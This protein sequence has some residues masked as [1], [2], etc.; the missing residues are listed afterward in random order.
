LIC[1]LHLD[2]NWPEL[3]LQLIIFIFAGGLL[4]SSANGIMGWVH[5]AYLVSFLK[6]SF[7]EKEK[8]NK[9]TQTYQ[10]FDGVKLGME[11]QRKNRNKATLFSCKIIDKLFPIEFQIRDKLLPI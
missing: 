6:T 8:N 5:G 4:F 2:K 3:S 7:A 11:K 1:F 10:L 9:K